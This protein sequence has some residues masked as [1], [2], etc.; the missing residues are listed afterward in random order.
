MLHRNADR[1]WEIGYAGRSLLL[2]D[3]K[4]LGYLSLLLASPGKRFWAK[5]LLRATRG[6]APTP[7]LARLS[8]TKALKATLARVTHAHPELG[9]HLNATVRRGNFCV[10]LPDPRRPISWRT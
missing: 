8:V 7:E 2:P 5:D 4:G 6:H 10:Y 1:V 3:S 9:E